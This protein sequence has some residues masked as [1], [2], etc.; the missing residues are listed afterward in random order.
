M[1]QSPRLL[2]PAHLG[3]ARKVPPLGLLVELGSG[4]V[5]GS[6]PPLRLR[7]ATAAPCFPR[8]VRVFFGMWAIVF[9]FR[10]ALIAFFTFLRAPR[11]CFSLAMS[12]PPCQPGHS[13]CTQAHVLLTL[14]PRPR[15]GFAAGAPCAIRNRVDT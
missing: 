10:A 11:R 12:T 7:R 13:P 14:P 9:F 6:E 1:T 5:F 2:A 8:A 4:L 15:S 3:A